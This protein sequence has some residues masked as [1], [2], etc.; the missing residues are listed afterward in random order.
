MVKK[1]ELMMIGRLDVQVPT[2]IKLKKKSCKKY[3]IYNYICKMCIDSIELV[4]L[5][6]WACRIHSSN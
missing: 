3:V 6:Y 2:G 4:V 5:K 1:L